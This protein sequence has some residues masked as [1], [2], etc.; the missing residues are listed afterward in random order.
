LVS[1]KAG[2]VLLAILLG[3]GY[4]LLRPQPKAPEA[5]KLVPC[6]SFNTVYARFEGGGKVTEFERP[7]LGDNWILKQPVAGPTDRT[8]VEYYVN[9]IEGIKIVNTVDK[10]AGLGQYG[11]D[12]PHMVVTCRLG[13][14]A[15]YTLTVGGKSFDGSAYYAQKRGDPKVYVISAVEVDGFDRTLSEPPI[16][17]SPEPGAASPSPAM[18]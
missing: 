6:D 2:L 5:P 10:P 14:G 16:K 12:R 4:I 1:W 3:L 9:S 11:L 8:T 18:P 7:K 17:P 15:S 13:N